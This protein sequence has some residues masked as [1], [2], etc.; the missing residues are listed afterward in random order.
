MRL[1]WRTCVS[2][3]FLFACHWWLSAC[4]GEHLHMMPTPVLF[5]D[6][7]LDMEKRLFPELRS[8]QLPVFYATNRIPV[9]PARRGITRQ[10][11]VIV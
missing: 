1:R 4:A 5:K 8:T 3:L 7:R 10:E 11:R 6:E 9:S 2:W